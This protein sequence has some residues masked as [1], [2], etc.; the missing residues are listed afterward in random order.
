MKLTLWFVPSARGPCASSA[1]LKISRSSGRFSRTWDSGLCVQGPRLPVRRTQ[2]G[3][4]SV[5][6]HY[7]IPKPPILT[8]T[9]RTRTLTPM[10]IRNIPGMI[11]SSHNALCFFQ[12]LFK[13]HRR[14]LS[15]FRLNDLPRRINR[16][17]GLKVNS[18]DASP[19]RLLCA[20]PISCT[21]Y[22]LDTSERFLYCRQLKASSDQ[23]INQ[24]TGRI[25][26]SLKQR[27]PIVDMK[28]GSA[29]KSSSRKSTGK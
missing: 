13:A 18:L 10:P 26:R 27:K 25:F 9:P 6:P 28:S 14:G 15:E 21:Q 12:E 17:A 19:K 24:S 16:Q 29:A 20:H 23:S 3:P 1:L 8:R 2:T 22:L 4:K 7:W 5:P 11:T